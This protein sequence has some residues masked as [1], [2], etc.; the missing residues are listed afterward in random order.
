MKK[1]KTSV[2]HKVLTIVGII[3]CV[4][5]IPILIIVAILLVCAGDC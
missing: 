4:I 3:L 5:L 2:A 1:E